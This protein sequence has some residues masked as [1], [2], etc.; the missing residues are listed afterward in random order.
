MQQD[1]FMHLNNSL[2]P[3]AHMGMYSMGSQLFKNIQEIDFHVSLTNGDNWLV[4]FHAFLVNRF[5]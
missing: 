4:I 3:M 1:D 2:C 5:I